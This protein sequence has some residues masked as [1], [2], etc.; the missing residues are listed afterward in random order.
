MSS[1][2]MELKRINW[3]ETLGFVQIFKSF[4]MAI[5]PT[6]LALCFVAVAALFVGG[7]AMDWIWGLCGQR[8]MDGEVAAYVTQPAGEFSSALAQWKDKDKRANAANDLY[9]DAAKH[10]QLQEQY[11]GALDLKVNGGYFKPAF[12]ELLDGQQKP[13]IGNLPQEEWADA[14]RNARKAFDKQDDTISRLIDEANASAHDKI[15]GDSSLKPED[16][17]KAYGQV[18]NDHSA[19]LQAQVQLRRDFDEKEKS[20]RGRSIFGMFL[21]FEDQAVSDAIAA[22]WRL[23]FVSGMDRYTDMMR[24]RNGVLPEAAATDSD[25]AMN[26]LVAAGG[27]PVAGGMG[28]AS[29]ASAKAGFICNMLVAFMGV[30]WLFSAHWL[31]AI[32]YTALALC[33][34]ALVGG[35]VNR[36]AALHF[37]REEKISYMQAL[38]FSAGKFFSFA[39]APLIPLALILV[40]GLF[41]AFGGFISANWAPEGGGIVLGLLFFVAIAL[42]LAVAF[43]LIGLVA[44]SPLMYPTIAVEG[45][46][47]FD[48][49]S[50]S[51]SYVY[52]RPWH[53]LFYGLVALIYGAL[54]YLFVRL[55]AFVT[56]ASAHMFLKWFVFRTGPTVGSEADKIDVLWKA[57]TFDSLFFGHFNWDAMNKPEAVGAFF[58]GVWVFVVAGT[59]AAYLLSYL[60]SSTTVAYFL[61][62]RK[63]DATDLDDVYVEESPEAPLTEVSPALSVSQPAA[64]AGAGGAAAPAG[65]PPKSADTPKP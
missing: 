2:Q 33:V 34:V 23:D 21:K 32:V 59:T 46:D 31:F 48:A 62:R 44:G 43:L 9:A 3:I 10:R 56:L 18:K 14:L 28:R 12:K 38:R 5:H 42:G 53:A 63:V 47:S 25:R 65:E 37:A 30:E 4:K 50:R 40:L 49:M 8:A 54:T 35:A 64:D 17:D 16:K 57:P 45:S 60:A 11:W 22:V 61:L 58:I 52:G 26:Q 51:Y 13:D 20:I 29:D 7:W 19:A 24:H 6:K 27:G 1:E 55:F 39:T 36:I 41:L 15:K